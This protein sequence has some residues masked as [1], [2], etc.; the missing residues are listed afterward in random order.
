MKEN[1]EELRIAMEKYTNEKMFYTEGE[2]Y[3]N[4]DA[5]IEKLEGRISKLEQHLTAVFDR[6]VAE[7]DS[8]IQSIITQ[9]LANTKNELLNLIEDRARAAAKENAEMLDARIASIEKKL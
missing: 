7:L 5:R 1:L 9:Q 2:I 4:V 6:K 3:K 8:K